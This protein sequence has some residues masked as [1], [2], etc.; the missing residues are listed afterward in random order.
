[1]KKIKKLKLNFNKL[2]KNFIKN[3]NVQYVFWN[4]MNVKNL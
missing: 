1:M 4:K 3:I 2:L